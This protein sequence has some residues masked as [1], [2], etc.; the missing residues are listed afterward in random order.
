M[1]TFM[2]FLYMFIVFFCLLTMFVTIIN[3]AFAAVCDDMSKQSNDYEMFDFI[4][5]RF[6]H[7]SGIAT[8]QKRITGQS[9][10]NDAT[11]VNHGRVCT[12]ELHWCKQRSRYKQL[13]VGVIVKYVIKVSNNI[14]HHSIIEQH[15]EQRD[16]LYYNHRVPHHCITSTKGPK[17]TQRLTKVN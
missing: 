16:L 4:I 6:K 13:W 2:F 11:N 1:G 12:E 15:S 17:K 8:L 5:D 14:N 7:W 10:E 3:E 9:A